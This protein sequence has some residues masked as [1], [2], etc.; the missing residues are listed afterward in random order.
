M[1]TGP[2]VARLSVASVVFCLTLTACADQASSPGLGPSSG[3][4]SSSR[5]PSPSVSSV[6]SPEIQHRSPTVSPTAASA[7]IPPSSLSPAGL[8][9]VHEKRVFF[10]HQSVGYNAIKGMNLIS[11]KIGVSTFSYYDVKSERPRSRGAGFFAHTKVGQNGFPLRKIAEFDS[12]IRGDLGKDLDIAFL[13]LCYVDF[14]AKADAVAIFRA[15]RSAVSELEKDFPNIIFLHATVPLEVNA[16]RANQVRTRFNMLMRDHYGRA[17][18]LWDIAKAEAT[19]PEG[20][21]IGGKDFEALYAKYSSDG[22][23]LNETGAVAVAEPLLRLL[24]AI[25]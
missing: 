21:R 23:H 16:P 3:P 1:R 10:G 20:K 5:G 6:S 24:V 17:G 8:S 7:S 19:D 11:Q 13:K 18:R 12:I 9:R 22:A 14:G 4:S 25:S 15:Y 2:W